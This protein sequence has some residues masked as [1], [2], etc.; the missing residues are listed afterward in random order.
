[1]SG[2]EDLTIKEEGS[3]LARAVR[4]TTHYISDGVDW[5]AERNRN[6]IGKPY[7]AVPG[8]ILIGNWLPGERQKSFSDPQASY[9]KKCKY[10]RS[11]FC[12]AA[13]SKSA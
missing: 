3:V 10:T 6:W 1:M 2:L 8:W 4:K 12:S 7:A 13:R 11:N 9:L 5:F